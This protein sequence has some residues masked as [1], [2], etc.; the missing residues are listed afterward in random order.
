MNLERALADTF[1]GFDGGWAFW[2]AG[3]SQLALAIE[4]SRERDGAFNAYPKG[5]LG[6]FARDLEDGLRLLSIAVDV[7][8]LLQG[9]PSSNGNRVDLG[10]LLAARVRDL[11][12]E[13]R[14]L[15]S[16]RG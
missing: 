11:H 10:E 6:R 4:R 16:D 5:E 12:V 13:T 2:L 9:E 7:Q 14:D 8:E 3:L 15:T 1:G